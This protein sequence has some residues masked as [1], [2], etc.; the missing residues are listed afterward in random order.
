MD[1]DLKKNKTEKNKMKRNCFKLV[2]LA[3]WSKFI[4]HY[5][6]VYD[7]ALMHA[8]E[9]NEKTRHILN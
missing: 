4:I 1:Y 3:E 9:R 7:K 6:D 8:K 5:L 2:A